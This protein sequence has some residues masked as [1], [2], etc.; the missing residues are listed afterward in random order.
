MINKKNIVVR[1]SCFNG[2]IE[3]KE[4][5]QELR[6]NNEDDPYNEM[7]DMFKELSE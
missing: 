5:K 4:T 1:A 6:K 3:T 7:D 2:L